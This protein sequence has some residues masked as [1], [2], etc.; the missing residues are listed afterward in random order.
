VRAFVRDSGKHFSGMNVGE[1]VLVELQIDLYSG[2]T[3]RLNRQKSSPEVSFYGY[4]IIR[5]PQDWRHAALE[6]YVDL[7]G[8]NEE[9]KIV[10]EE[11]VDSGDRGWWWWTPPPSKNPPWQC[12]VEIRR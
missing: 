5:D 1:Q 6:V 10:L 11:V 3:W 2:Y 4:R 12:T 8:A 7:N 9:A